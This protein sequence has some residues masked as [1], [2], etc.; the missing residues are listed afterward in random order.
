MHSAVSQQRRYL[1]NR[2]RHFTNETNLE[3]E[4]GKNAMQENVKE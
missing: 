1:K 4:D 2:G 3:V